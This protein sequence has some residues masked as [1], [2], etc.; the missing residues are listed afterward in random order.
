MHAPKLAAASKLAK[1]FLAAAFCMA[2]CAMPSV[3]H[4]DGGVTCTGF[5]LYSTP[6][7]DNSDTSSVCPSPMA[8]DEVYVDPETGIGSMRKSTASPTLNVVPFMVV[9]FDKNVG[10]PKTLDDSAFV[11]RNV[12][13]I[14]IVR[15]RDGYEVATHAYSSMQSDDRRC[16]YVCL[17]EW[18][19]PLTNYE[20]V[21][22]A[23]IEAANG[24][25][26]SA[27]EYRF[28]IKTGALC[29]IGLTVFQI[30]WIAA[31]VALVAC[32]VAWSVR[33]VRKERA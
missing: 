19:D 33:R 1:R 4:A 12:E 16:L 23:G 24:V 29:K 6:Y 22:D 30:G 17:D 25:D 7:C 8:L 13:R 26:V 10:C 32:G 21:V 5:S 20:I 3:A 31:A 11:E 9:M 14:R 27:E 15:V 18:M 2:L 28:P